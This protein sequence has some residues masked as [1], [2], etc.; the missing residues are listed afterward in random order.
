MFDC[1]SMELMRV[2]WLNTILIVTI[3]QR[4][5]KRK[6]QCHVTWFIILVL[7]YTNIGSEVTKKKIKKNKQHS[8]ALKALKVCQ[9]EQ[10]AWASETVPLCVAD[11]Q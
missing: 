4:E 2:I 10:F 3:V 6:S 11:F 7:E 9:Y 8:Q 5:A 1:D